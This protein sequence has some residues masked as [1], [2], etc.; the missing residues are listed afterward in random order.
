MKKTR[1]SVSNIAQPSPSLGVVQRALV[2]R[3]E[4]I[5]KIQAELKTLET[6][7]AELVQA[8]HTQNGARLQLEELLGA[9]PPEPV[10]PEAPE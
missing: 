5:S 9:A 2:E 1:G 10:T 8:L 3:K 6:R 4:T 7:Q